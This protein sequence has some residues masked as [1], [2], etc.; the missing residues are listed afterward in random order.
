MARRTISDDAFAVDGL[1]KAVKGFRQLDKEA[2]RAV[3][4][5]G[6]KVGKNPILADAVKNY[7]QVAPGKWKAHATT[8]LGLTSTQTGAGVVLK[9]TKHPE[10][11]SMEFGAKVHRMPKGRGRKGEIR[12]VLHGDMRRR[13]APPWV[14][15][16]HTGYNFGDLRGYV[17]TKAIRQNRD[18]VIVAYNK[19]LTDLVVKHLR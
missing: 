4:Q 13:L 8:A 12:T 2:E 10:A 7:R 19:E 17:V 5:L 9:S 14:G 18:K 1:S 11:A 6:K 16:Q 15:N 3:K